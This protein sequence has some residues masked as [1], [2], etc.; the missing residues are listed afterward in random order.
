MANSE[1][2]RPRSDLLVGNAE[3]VCLR[4]LKRD[5]CES[6]G[7]EKFINTVMN[8]NYAIEM[9]S[10]KIRDDPINHTYN[11]NTTIPN[12]STIFNLCFDNL[13]N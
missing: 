13:Q 6:R 3:T 11:N 1:K 2:Q 4:M 5:I 9:E 7:W 8:L 10:I 12:C